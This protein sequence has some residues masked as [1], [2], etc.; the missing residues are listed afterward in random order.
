[1]LLVTCVAGDLA[2]P[3]ELAVAARH[4]VHHLLHSVHATAG[5]QICTFSDLFGLIMCSEV[6]L[7]GPTLNS[8]VSKVWVE[9]AIVRAWLEEHQLPLLDLGL[10]GLL[11]GPPAPGHAVAAL[12]AVAYLLC[13]SLELRLKNAIAEVHLGSLFVLFL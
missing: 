12:H 6:H 10:L 1:M 2:A 9:G 4:N 5:A 13:C 3:L 8:L 11:G 7:T